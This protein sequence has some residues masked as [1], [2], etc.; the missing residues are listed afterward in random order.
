MTLWTSPLY[1]TGN[2]TPDQS[3]SKLATIRATLS[4]LFCVRPD[5]RK[6]V[7]FILAGRLHTSTTQL[8][9]NVSKLGYGRGLILKDESISFAT[10]LEPI[11][12]TRLPR[13]HI[14]K[15]HASHI[16][17]FV[18]NLH[19]QHFNAHPT[20]TRIK[21]ANGGTQTLADVGFGLSRG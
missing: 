1:P 5:R 12:M 15:V 3:A 17:A 8:L 4:C 11:S 16:L 9:Y 10:Q 7:T 13:L 6:L 2:L 18:T 21:R 19:V 14:S 20:R